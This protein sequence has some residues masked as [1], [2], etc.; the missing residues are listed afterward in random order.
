MSLA[1]RPRTVRARRHHETAARVEH[2]GIEGVGH[3]RSA[4]PGEHH[5]GTTGRALLALLVPEA[6]LELDDAEAAARL[7]GLDAPPGGERLA[8]QVHA[9]E[10]EAELPGPAALAC[11]IGQELDHDVL[12][13]RSVHHH[14]GQL[15]VRG[16]VAPVVVDAMPILHGGGPAHDVRGRHGAFHEIG[17][18][19]TDRD[20]LEIDLCHR[21]RLS[22]G[23][24]C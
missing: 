24:S 18:S 8:G 5:G 7:L 16:R 22:A 6:D 23:S 12:L 19:S 10:L 15:V 4:A 3:G 14:V 13:P 1:A 17:N 21:T 11:P 9:A 2:A 20:V